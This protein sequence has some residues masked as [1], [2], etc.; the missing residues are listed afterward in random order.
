MWSCKIKSKCLDVAHE[1]PDSNIVA[2]HAH[3]LPWHSRQMV[4]C[5]PHTLGFSH[6]RAPVHDV[7]SFWDNVASFLF[8]KKVCTPL[9]SQFECHHEAFLQSCVKRAPFLH[10][11]NSLV[12]TFTTAMITAQGK[13]VYICLSTRLWLLWE[14]DSCLYYHY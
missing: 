8:L 10:T 2:H 13:N 12:C 4:C 14:R 11:G 9:N 3:I 1:T 6:C 7:P 5:F